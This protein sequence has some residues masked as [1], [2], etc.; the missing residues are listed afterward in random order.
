MMKD[1]TCIHC[2]INIPMREEE[3]P[4]YCPCG[5]VGK[6]FKETVIEPH[7]LERRNAETTEDKSSRGLGDTV[8][9]VTKKLGIR[10]CGGCKKRQTL[11][12][13]IFPYKKGKPPN[14]H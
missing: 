9:K 13:K 1:W 5:A 14:A 11:L 6:S 2:G 7:P 3:F 12:N 4:I 8:A 10:S